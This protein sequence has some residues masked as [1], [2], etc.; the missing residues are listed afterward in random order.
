MSFEIFQDKVGPS[1]WHFSGE[2]WA[3]WAEWAEQCVIHRHHDIMTSWHFSQCSQCLLPLWLSSTV[4]GQSSLLQLRAVDLFLF[5]VVFV[6]FVFGLN[7]WSA[8]SGA[9]WGAVVHGLRILHSAC[10]RRSM[11]ATKRQIRRNERHKFVCPLAVHPRYFM[12]C[13]N[14]FVAFQALQ[15]SCAFLLFYIIFLIAYILSVKFHSS[16]T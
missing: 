11:L 15:R 6:V 13:L 12:N 9:W 2:R 8:S 7:H 10:K 16:A 14:C 1:S 4:L 3:E 5:V